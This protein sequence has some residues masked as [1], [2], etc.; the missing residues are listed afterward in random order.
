MAVTSWVAMAVVVVC[1]WWKLLVQGTT[2]EL[3]GLFE[4]DALD[5]KG[6][7]W[8]AK[9]GSRIREG[10]GKAVSNENGM[11][12]GEIE[13]HPIGNPPLHPPSPMLHDAIPILTRTI[14]TAPSL[15]SRTPIP[16]RRPP[17]TKELSGLQE[18]F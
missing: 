13:V 17:T 4:T 14:H 6:R 16:T 11:K 1:K 8:C 5:G 7:P 3:I 15:Q 18:P 12:I 10:R 2:G 9:G